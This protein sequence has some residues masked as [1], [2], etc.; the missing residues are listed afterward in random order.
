FEV[1][2]TPF[3]GLGGKQQVSIAGG[4]IPRWRG[5]GKELFYLAADNKLMAA[6]VNIKGSAIEVG[7]VRP[8]F[9]ILP[10]QQGRDFDVTA[11]GQR[12][13]VNTLVEDKES[14]PL[15]LVINWTADVKR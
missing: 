5:D 8:L 13:L 12:F 11:D 15:T 7:A 10:A 2:V 9:D 3:P 1:Y 14:L 6:E 4:R